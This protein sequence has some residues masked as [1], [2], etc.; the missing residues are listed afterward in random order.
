MGRLLVNCTMSG[1][2]CDPLRIGSGGQRRGQAVPLPDGTGDNNPAVAATVGGPGG[3]QGSFLLQVNHDGMDG[4]LVAPG[5]KT[6]RAHQV[7]AG[8]GAVL[9]Q[10][11]A[12]G[13]S[14][15]GGEH[16]SGVGCLIIVPCRKGGHPSQSSSGV[17][18][19]TTRSRAA[20]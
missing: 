14:D 12:D 7:G 8:Q 3:D 18:A 5:V 11:G 9:D 1:V 20:A 6:Q 19:H 16:W 2:G 17:R 10:R 13:G 15:Q 4:A